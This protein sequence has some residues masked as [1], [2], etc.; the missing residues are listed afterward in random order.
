MTPRWT[1]SLLAPLACCLTL[2]A[3]LPSSPAMGGDEA[4]A[5]AAASQAASGA[6][7]AATES[8]RQARAL[9]AAMANH[10]AHLQ[11]F[12]VTM[13]DSYDVVQSSGQKI[14]FGETRRITMARPDRLRVEE[15]ASDGRQD[16][17]LF[18]GRNVTVLDADTNAFAQAPQPGTVDD[19][20]VYFVRDLKMRMPLARLLMTRLPEEWPR[21]VLAVDYVETADV[22]GVRT[23]HL[24]GR[25]DTIDFQYWITEGEHPLPLRV[26]ITYVN[27]PGQPQFRAD[28]PDWNTSPKLAA[29]SF[30]FTQPQGAH[31][32]AFA[33]QVQ[34]STGTTQPPAAIE[35]AKP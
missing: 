8:Q 2:A 33:A 31:R 35:E 27:S 28:F 16:L 24:A 11:N 32:I 21:R 25:T 7:P 22:H 5:A 10:L 23:H 20:L 14:E 4:A 26:V 3:A 6:T 17:T 18:D 9:L 13:R 34:G 15:I 30:E 12:T 1:R 29:T 19:T